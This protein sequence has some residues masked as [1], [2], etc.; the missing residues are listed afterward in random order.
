[1]NGVWVVD[2]ATVLD[3]SLIA[4][5]VATALRLREQPGQTM[6]ETLI[7]FLGDK[8]LLL[9]LDNC[10]QIVSACAVLAEKLLKSCPDLCILATS[11]E[12][13]G[14]AGETTWRVPSLPIPS[15]T[16]LKSFEAIAQNPSVRLFVDRAASVVYAFRLSQ[17]IVP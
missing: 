12:G 3:P 4:T 11:R 13:L 10:E 14:I 7:A 8:R 17:N 6:L 9:I 5:M 2:M 1:T 16:G 15:T